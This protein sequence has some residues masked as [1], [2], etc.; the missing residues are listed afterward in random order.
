MY[1]DNR[2]FY[3]NDLYIKKKISVP[4]M[5][6][7]QFGLVKLSF[8]RQATP[9][10]PFWRIYWNL[11]PGLRVSCDEQTVNLE[12]NIIL[13]IPP[14]TPVNQELLVPCNSF[15]LHVDTGKE[16]NQHE[17]K[18]FPIPVD[19]VMAMMLEKVT[20]VLDLQADN[21]GE[22][23]SAFTHLV[24]TR[25]PNDIWQNKIPDQRIR[26][27]VEIL[28]N[29]PEK[30][31]TNQELA[32]KCFICENAFVRLFRQQAG[33]PPQKFLQEQRLRLSTKLLQGTDLTIEE[34]AECCGFC[35]RNYFTKLFKRRY[36]IPPA[37]FRKQEY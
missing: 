11:E 35:D 33:I 13:A 36:E 21:L 23:F 28:Q 25:L 37:A 8:S 24:M 2:S 32:A 19:K 9:E 7:S 15:F 18:I 27:I 5:R 12:K 17:N 3:I 14:H 31:Y 26:D 10:R 30:D 29:H 22:Y 6:I 20:G 16:Y 34:V 4:E 1:I